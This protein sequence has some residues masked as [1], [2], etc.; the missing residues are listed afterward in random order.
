M[1]LQYTSTSQHF[2]DGVF[3]NFLYNFNL[4]KD[5]D[6]DTNSKFCT[7]SYLNWEMQPRTQGM[8]ETVSSLEK[9][10]TYIFAVE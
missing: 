3:L 7:I 8:D 2:V 6:E 10:V 5:A 9:H 4:R 1:F